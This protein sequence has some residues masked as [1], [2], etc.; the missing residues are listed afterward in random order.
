MDDLV[1]HEKKV[2]IL[3]LGMIVKLINISWFL[4]KGR[5]DKFH[6]SLGD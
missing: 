4:L 6:S 5:I 1:R 2:R 3:P